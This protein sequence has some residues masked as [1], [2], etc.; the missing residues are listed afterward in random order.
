MRYNLFNVNI[1]V[2]LLSFCMASVLWYV[3]VVREQV[4]MQVSVQVEYKGLPE[5]LVVTEGLVN[6][7]D[8]RLRGPKA[9]LNDIPA[10]SRT[11]V[12]DLSGLH[13]GRNV[14]PF[15]YLRK[16][17]LRA[18]EVQSIEPSRIIV[19]ADTM[20]ER[21][22]SIKPNVL[23]PLNSA[24]LKISDLTVVPSSVLVRGPSATV[25]NIN[26]IP[27]TVRINPKAEAGPY[28]QV[29]PLDFSKSNVSVAPAQVTVSY[30]VL[31]ERRQIKII[32]NIKILAQKVKDYSI[33]PKQIEMSVQVPEALEN[34]SGY[35]HS[36]ELS[37]TP[38]LLDV[39]EGALVPLR[40]ILPEGMTLV[41]NLP[42]VIT[43]RRHE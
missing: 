22:V 9:L 17:N 19:I 36:V 7:I 11:H 3:V 29:E 23:S 15:T 34:N 4:D 24:N 5:G 27:L 39:G 37:V 33:E 35:L 26:N 21:N 2:L 20:Q 16:K 43:L 10:S 31:S 18:L 41:E 8:V 28:S 32:K 6:S 14:L 38:P 1:P 12:V 40:V 13:K 25:N 30:T 42:E